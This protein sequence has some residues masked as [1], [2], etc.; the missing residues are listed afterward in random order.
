MPKKYVKKRKPRFLLSGF[1]KVNPE[2]PWFMGKLFKMMIR[3]AGAIGTT[4]RLCRINKK[5]FYL[6]IKRDPK[7]KAE[8]ERMRD[9]SIGI[10]EDEAIRRSVDGIEKPV[11]YKGEIVGYTREFSDY[12][13]CKLLA[14]YRSNW[15]YPK[16]V[17]VLASIP[18]NPV[19]IAVDFKESDIKSD[20]EEDEP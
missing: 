7:F 15:R 1:L 16:E 11:F 2:D 20:A 13:L 14:A 8:Y 9:Y 6:A 10:A 18:Y 4:L 12:L 17:E 5:D 19:P 3:C